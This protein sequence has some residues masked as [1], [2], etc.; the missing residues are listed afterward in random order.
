MSNGT[1]PISGTNLSHPVTGSD[2]IDSSSNVKRSIK[3]VAID[4]LRAAFDSQYEEYPEFRNMK[5]TAEFPIKN[6]DFP[7]VVVF[8]QGLRVRQASVDR[9]TLKYED[10]AGNT[11]RE[12]RR[13]FEA[14]L[15][16]WHG[17]WTSAQMAKLSDALI[18]VITF[19]PGNYL[20]AAVQT[21]VPGL[22][23][24]SDNINF[25][26]EARDLA[27]EGGDRYIYYDVASIPIWGE[28]V[29]TAQ[30]GIVTEVD[31]VG[32]TDQQEYPPGW[33]W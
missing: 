13:F 14:T 21:N 17:A 24:G 18:D 23:F 6:E 9:V 16:L 20:L 12:E 32:V 8:L 10:D 5:I 4:G 15:G 29:M 11:W 33:D 25:Q 27:P 2:Y 7:S 1:P 19:D 3:Q 28:V 30:F 22:I 31:V 26:G